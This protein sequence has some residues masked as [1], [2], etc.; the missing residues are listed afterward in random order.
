MR[1]ELDRA[2]EAFVLAAKFSAAIEARLD[3]TKEDLLKN[4][5]P[6]LRQSNFPQLPGEAEG[7]RR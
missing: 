6:V 7:I 1:T 2:S 4:G 5:F 3:V